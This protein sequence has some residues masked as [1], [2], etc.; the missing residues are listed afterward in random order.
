MWL[1]GETSEKD[2]FNVYRIGLGDVGGGVVGLAGA[3]RPERARDSSFAQAFHSSQ[4]VLN[5]ALAS[6]N[7]ATRS[8]PLRAGVVKV[9]H[10][11]PPPASLMA[12]R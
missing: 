9:H 10:P 2:H 1:I 11:P 4:L 3:R 5:W 6:L 8:E 12:T 7:E